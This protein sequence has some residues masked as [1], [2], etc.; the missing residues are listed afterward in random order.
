MEPLRVKADNI[1][2]A[3]VDALFL[4]DQRIGGRLSANATVM[5]APSEP[6]VEGEFALT[7]G[8]FRTYT[9]ESLAGKVQYVKDGVTLDVRLQQTPSEWLTAKGFA[10]LTLFKPTPEELAGA[11]QPATPGDTVDLA[12]ESSQINLA[13]IQG[14]TSYITR[15]DRRSPGQHQSDRLRV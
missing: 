10:P 2:V 7:Q 11:H 12:V 5:G 4:G 1:D 8:S 9:F 6:R 15:C 14:F 13:L 3:Q